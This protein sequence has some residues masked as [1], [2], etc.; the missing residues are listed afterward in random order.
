M[1]LSSSTEYQQKFR[2]GE[3]GVIGTDISGSDGATGI[4]FN[5]DGK[6]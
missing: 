6:E 5:K 1:G 3:C 4:L 2:D